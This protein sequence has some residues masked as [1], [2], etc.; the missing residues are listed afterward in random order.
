MLGRDVLLGG[1]KRGV[2]D[3]DGGGKARD[4]QRAPLVGG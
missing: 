2:R 3:T 4:S 1:C